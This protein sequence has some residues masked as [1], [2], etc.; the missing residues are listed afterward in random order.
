MLDRCIT[1][2][3]Q[4]ASQPGLC[5]QCLENGAGR[6]EESWPCCSA[7]ATGS[8][9][10]CCYPDGPLPDGVSCTSDDD[11]CPS[12]REGARAS[13]CGGDGQCHPCVEPGER[14][15]TGAIQGCC[16]GEAFPASRMCPAQCIYRGDVVE[17]GQGG[18]CGGQSYI[19]CEGSVGTCRG[20]PPEERNCRDDDCDARIDEGLPTEC[21]A[22]VPSSGSFQGCANLGPLTGREECVGGRPVCRVTQGYCAWDRLGN[23][24]NR[25]P[26]GQECF[27]YGSDC[28]TSYCAAGEWCCSAT[29]TSGPTCS[30]IGYLIQPGAATPVLDLPPPEACWRPGD[31]NEDPSCPYVDPLCYGLVCN[32]CLAERGCGFC[33]SVCLPGDASGPSG[34]LRCE[35]TDWLF[36]EREAPRCR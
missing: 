28:S 26:F 25:A 32:D 13:R 10:R 24:I 15:P 11:C 21:R 34:G 4:R 9:T 22:V 12:A 7:A 2:V 31:L 18:C 20:A 29:S 8:A 23:P 17:D 19:M 33:N 5:G 1:N 3:P 36:G 35:P 16:F 6:G 30:R 27:R 14:I